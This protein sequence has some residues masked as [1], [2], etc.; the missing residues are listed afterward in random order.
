[1][2]RNTLNFLVDLISLL[3]ML[4]LAW[5]GLLIHYGLPPGSGGRG[6]GHGMRLWGLG[7]HDYGSIHFFLASALIGLMVIHIWLHWSWVCTTA[8]KLAGVKSVNGKRGTIHGIALLVIIAALML[9]ALFYANTLVM[10]TA[11]TTNH[12]PL[13]QGSLSSLRISGQTTLAEAARIGRIPVEELIL[14]LSLPSDVDID[15][16]LGRLKRQYRFEIHDVRRILE[17]K[18]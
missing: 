1:M 5:T 16:R 10:G 8:K 3:L 9:W 17:Q 18:E 7:R 12:E 13:E 15:E 6:G 2:K 14:K 11:Q 4:G